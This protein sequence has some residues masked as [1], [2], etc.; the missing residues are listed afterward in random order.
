M[1]LVLFS[2]SFSLSPLLSFFLSLWGLL[3]LGLRVG[4]AWVAGH[5]GFEHDQ[6]FEGHRAIGVLTEKVRVRCLPTFITD[7]VSRFCF[8]FEKRA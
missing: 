3:G 1:G 2:L 5:L 6:W 7:K 4:G 8:E